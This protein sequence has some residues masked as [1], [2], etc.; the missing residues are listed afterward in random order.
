MCSAAFRTVTAW[1]HCL[2]V[3]QLRTS[4]WGLQHARRPPLLATCIA[5][6]STE[7]CHVL[8]I[9]PTKKQI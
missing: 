2:A 5:S 7:G 1:Q 9:G 6:R 4:S 8:S 3:L